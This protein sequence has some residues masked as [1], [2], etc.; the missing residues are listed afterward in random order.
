MGLNIDNRVGFMV[1]GVLIFQVLLA[2]LFCLS[3]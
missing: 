1:V 3:Y 2:E